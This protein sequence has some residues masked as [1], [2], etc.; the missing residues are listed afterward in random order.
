MRISTRGNT[1]MSVRSLALGLAALGAALCI[2]GTA[3]AV[4]GEDGDITW[5]AGTGT[6]AP[7]SYTPLTAAVTA[8]ATSL[9]VGAGGVTALA[10]PGC[11][12]GATC[13]NA[14]VPPAI[15][16][17][18]AGY[19]P[20]AS[21]RNLGPGDLLMIYQPQDVNAAAAVI[22]T[23]NTAAFGA[24]LDNSTSAHQAGL[25][26]FVYV[27]SVS[28]GTINIVTTTGTAPNGSACAG[29]Q[30]SYDIGAMVIRVPQLRNLSLGGGNVFTPPAWNG[31]I[32]GVVAVEVGRRA[33]AT[34]ALDSGGVLTFSGTA[35][36]HADFAGFRGGSN[37]LDDVTN[38]IHNTAF[39]YSA[40]TNAARKGESIFG[41]S[42]TTSSAG[43][44]DTGA[45]GLHSAR[46]LGRG[47]LANGGGGGNAHNSG[48]GG[49]AN[50]GVLA[51]WNGGGNPTAG[52]TAQWA[53]EGGAVGLI[54]AGGGPTVTSA[55]TSSGG[56]RGGYSWSNGLADATRNS[57]TQGPQ[58]HV[59]GGFPTADCGTGVAPAQSWNGNCR[60]NV[61]GLGG[62]PLD[63]GTGGTQRFFFGGGGG[64]G[65]RNN[66]RA[67]SGANGGGLVFVMANEVVTTGTQV[68][69]RANGA[70]AATSAAPNNEANDAP[71][72]GGG[73][74][75]VVF[76]TNGAMPTGAQL[77]AIG[78]DGGDHTFGTPAA[79]PEAEGPGGG[80]GGGVVALRAPSGAPA[81]TVAGGLHGDT[82]SGPYAG[83][84][85]A[86][87]PFTPNGA[88]DGGAGQSITGPIRT[89][90]PFTCINACSAIAG[91]GD[92][93]TTPVTQA[94]F[95][96]ER[97][98]GNI[99][100]SFATAS[101]VANVGF[102][103]DGGSV[104]DA[105]NIRR[106]SG[107]I[108]SKS[109]DP[110]APR[111]YTLTLPSDASIGTLYLTDVDALGR[112]IR[113]G[114]FA[115]GTEYGKRPSTATYDWSAA[116]AELD[117][118][119]SRGTSDAAYLEVST[120]GMYRVT[121]E[122]LV[123]AGVNL[124]GAPIGEIAISDRAGPVAR[125]I[126]GGATFGPGSS[127]VFFGDPQPNLYSRTQT[128]LVE[129]TQN[130]N[131]VREIPVH[132]AAF[133]SSVVG[134]LATATARFA[135]AAMS[136]DVL[137]PTDSP[138]G[139]QTLTASSGPVSGDYPVALT[140]PAAAA[141][142]LRVML[143][144][145][146]DL[147]DAPTPDHSVRVFVNGALVD[148][149]RFDGITA[150]LIDVPVSN[151]VAGNNTV[152]VELPRDTGFDVDQVVVQSVEIDYAVHAR[153]GSSSLIAKALQPVATLSDRVFADGLGDVIDVTDV[154]SF[155]QFAIADRTASHAIWMAGARDVRELSVPVGAGLIGTLADNPGA[156]IIVADR[157][158]LPTPT[159]RAAPALM[160][161]P[162]GNA[163]W[164]AIAHPLFA[165][166]IAPLAAHRASQGLSTAIVDVEQLYRRYTA[167]NAHP[168]AI[169]AF[170]RDSAANLGTRYVTL[171]G[172]ANYNSVGLAGGGIATAS[173]VPTPYVEV[174]ALVNFAPA[175]ALYGDLTGDQVAEISVGRLPVRTAA[176]ATEAVRKLLA[177]ESQPAS[178]RFM[179]VSG[180]RDDFLG[181]DFRQA[182][183]RF[184]TAL[185]PGWSVSRI[186]VDSS[187]AAGARS[188][189]S[190]GL[191]LGASV[192]SYTGHSGP[193]MWGF[194]PMLSAS[195]VAAFPTSPNQPVLLQ[196]G[197]WTTYFLSP[198]VFGMGNT[199]L[200]SPNRG[201]A[202]VF[203]STVLLDQP[204]HDRMAA[205]LGPLLRPGTRLGDAIDQARRQMATSSPI[206]TGPET[207]VGITLLGDPALIIR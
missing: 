166:A 101:E 190:S 110:S 7:N 40:C 105:R 84:S 168:D 98:G 126:S 122:A 136:Y 200:L 2:G 22:N 124:A 78:G 113:R 187:G 134:S 44:C 199:W 196:F 149:R 185:A 81:T 142:R 8:G 198:T 161:P 65:D 133:G 93:F 20:P 117:A 119:P 86:G 18:T 147:D 115:I 3:V 21:N 17:A 182:V 193:T 108:A 192:V 92:N 1:P 174:N 138:W 62:R 61:G 97:V 24:I 96:A 107:L 91:C 173:F 45:T 156:T 82:N 28:G 205:A 9:S 27:R 104:N 128:Y 112:E 183:D 202:S 63:R 109:G 154:P 135:A 103:L 181:M 50:G 74:G 127:V 90:G 131:L 141:G 64:A 56:G 158:A 169:K 189:L 67:T 167:G 53:L 14:L 188:A 57:S 60:A 85:A 6:Y 99:N 36:I 49:G 29:M 206:T 23:T 32:G 89:G 16:G 94:W 48:G 19:G 30:N 71:G 34:A 100:V 41:Y 178:Q 33:G 76:L 121:F 52:F 58:Y 175:D 207:L 176:E 165:D 54:S 51:N 77:Q 129:R 35:T 144:G 125:S 184:N 70:T 88:T 180:G 73:G 164:V 13:N 123:A 75:T 130:P 55:S 179:M 157:N 5:T 69:V 47:A 143:Y 146:I 80:G 137:S 31:S 42:G 26:E 68:R 148:S 39:F 11:P 197:C 25:Y 162:A 195:D 15:T 177:Y 160:A 37:E 170:L 203:G 201:A 172:G 46:G 186:D 83:A 66:S 153:G 111:T 95:N 118:R 191:N 155:T 171:V 102:Y 114:P 43:N 139:I 72:G 132:G 116:L 59:S 163:A 145:G 87:F 152:R 204:N 150:N 106:I 140:A 4:P 38:D 79:H 151:L 194:E 10:L 159:V 12:T 120:R